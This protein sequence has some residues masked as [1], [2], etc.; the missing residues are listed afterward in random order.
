MNNLSQKMAIAVT[1]TVTGKGIKASVV[2][3]ILWQNTERCALLPGSLPPW[4][5]NC[6]SSASEWGRDMALGHLSLP[7]PV[8]AGLPAVPL[9]CHPSAGQLLLQQQQPWSQAGPACSRDQKPSPHLEDLCLA[10]RCLFFTSEEGTKCEQMGLGRINPF[11][12]SAVL[13]YL[14]VGSLRDFELSSSECSL[15]QLQ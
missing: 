12:M 5:E 15:M 14:C 2:L 3:I 6:H 1:S 10:D 8:P 11:F 9:L 7:F 13:L 4:K